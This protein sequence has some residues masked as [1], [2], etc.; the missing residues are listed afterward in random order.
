M[1]KANKGVVVVVVVADDNQEGQALEASRNIEDVTK[2]LKLILCKL[3]SLETKL[4]TVIETVS[5]LKTTVNKLECG[6][7][8]TRRSQEA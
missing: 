2:Q 6:R 7:Q 3:I 5:N 4:E 1:Y 8:S